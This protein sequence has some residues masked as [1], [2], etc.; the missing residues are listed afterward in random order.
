MENAETIL[1]VFLS[2]ALALFLVLAIVFLVFAIKVIRSVRRASA[3][4]EALAD[5]AGAFGEFVQHAA[6]PMLIGRLFSNLADS[7]FKKP[8]KSK[9]K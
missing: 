5:K 8:G 9:R 3:K 2:S 4:A 6:T 7:L 1:V